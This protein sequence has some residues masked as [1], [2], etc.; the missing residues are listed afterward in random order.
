MNKLTI[1]S[2]LLNVIRGLELS[3]VEV[4][5]LTVTWIT[6]YPFLLEDFGWEIQAQ[7]SLQN[8]VT[9]I[10]KLK[11]ILEKIHSD[12]D[13]AVDLKPDNAK[14]E[15]SLEIV[16]EEIDT[17]KE[18]LKDENAALSPPGEE[19][20]PPEAEV[21]EETMPTQDI[22]PEPPQPSPEE[23]KP[24]PGY[25]KYGKK[26]GRPPRKKPVAETDL[27][28]TSVVPPE[29]DLANKTEPEV[30]SPSDEKPEPAKP[31]ETLPP[32][33]DLKEVSDKMI[34]KLKYGKEYAYD[35]LYLVDNLYVRSG[36]K[37]RE[38]AGVKPVGIVI[39]YTK[40]NLPYEIVVYYT[41]EHAV[42]PLSTA[43][44]YAK[45]KLL[46]YK[47]VSWRIKNPTDDS[48]I[49]PVLQELNIIF[50]KMGGDELKG[51]YVDG[52]GQVYDAK[53]KLNLKIRYVCNIPLYDAQDGE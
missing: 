52:R 15:D 8:I 6:H 5:C 35:L 28:K 4:K 29:T 7:T 46:P 30:A 40:Q 42:I 12:E 23:V 31:E 3:P 17:A 38:E 26:L 24:R 34:N 44:K 2:D 39:P 27:P 16:S 43:K 14:A 18:E 25:S 9:E 51:E 49:R 33:T 1:A 13:I 11:V 53:S 10:E 50:K 48:Y 37:L 20:L 36:F 45:S 22:S 19:T 21:S 41:D 47:N 32:V